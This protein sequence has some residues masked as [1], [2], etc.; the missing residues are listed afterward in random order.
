MT[1]WSNRIVGEDVVAADQLLANPDNWREHPKHQ[2]DAIR[3]LLDQIGWVQR[4]IVNTTT[5]HLIDGHL[6]VEEALDRGQSVPVLYVQLSIEEEK[7]MLAALDPVAALATTDASKLAEL[8]E[9]MAASFPD[10]QRSLD[11][12]TLWPT[13]GGGKAGLTDPDAVPTKVETDIKIGDLFQLGAH[14]VICGDSTLTDT[15]AAVLGDL[16]PGLMTTDPP[17]GVEYDPSW[18]VKAGVGS[19]GG[20]MGVVKND[21]QVDW[22]AAWSLFPGDVAYV[23]HAGIYAGPVQASLEDA[24][25]QIRSQIIWRKPSLVL[26]RGHYHWQHEP[27]YYAVR[28]NRT[29][30]WVGGRK[31]STSWA[32]TP[33]SHRCHECGSVAIEPL[34]AQELESTIWDIEHND[35]HGTT[36][37]GTQKPVECFARAMRNHA[38]PVVYDPFLGSGSS[39]I[40]AEMLGRALVGGELDPEYVQQ[41]I[42]RWQN[43]TGKKATFLGSVLE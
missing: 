27:C 25:F 20:H 26:S 29:A 19:G 13:A 2:R 10:L 14:R 38:H 9:A 31:E 8:R 3:A 4:V 7:A 40:A 35:A 23:Y 21:D 12:A 30:S 28:K 24:A 18:R 39:L 5:G 42:T 43:F 22:T 32:I 15:V 16:S 11:A 34:S 1:D 37:H 36:T 6:R 33:V 17:Y 41:I